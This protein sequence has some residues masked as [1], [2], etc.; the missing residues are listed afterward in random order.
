MG[1]AASKFGTLSLSAGALLRDLLRSWGHRR[2]QSRLQSCVPLGDEGR[3][4]A[5]QNARGA[6][7]F[8]QRVSR[9]GHIFRSPRNASNGFGLNLMLAEVCVIEE[10][11]F[12]SQ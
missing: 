8:D 11:S 2:V 12:S 6:N 5:A 10:R 7:S 1:R 4:S 9:T 3:S